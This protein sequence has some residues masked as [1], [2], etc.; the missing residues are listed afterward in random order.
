MWWYI[1]KDDINVRSVW[2]LDLSRK[3]STLSSDRLNFVGKIQSIRAL[4]SKDMVSRFSREGSLGR[5][6][7]SQVPGRASRFP[8]RLLRRHNAGPTGQPMSGIFMKP[9]GGC[10]TYREVEFEQQVVNNWDEVKESDL[11]CGRPCCSMKWLYLL[12]WTIW[13]PAEGWCSCNLHPTYR[14]RGLTAAAIVLWDVCVVTT[15]GLPQWS[16]PRA[17]GAYMGV[18]DGAGRRLELGH[19]NP[20][21][22]MAHHVQ[23]R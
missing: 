3:T 4:R 2:N 14:W 11:A 10:C 22:I 16:Y 12:F 9:T 19:S 8:H 7:L 18:P 17:K 21:S 6:C 20:C 5:W 15:P 23:G 1:K 13:A